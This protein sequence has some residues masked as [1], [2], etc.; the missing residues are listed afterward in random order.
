MQEFPEPFY[1]VPQKAAYVSAGMNPERALSPTRPLSFGVNV[2]NPEGHCPNPEPLPYLLTDSL[3]LCGLRFGT[4][5][6]DVSTWYGVYWA[7]Y[8][9][10]GEP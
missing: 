7:G 8:Q 4:K 9:L 3:A 1:P 5:G 6:T 10:T 2:L